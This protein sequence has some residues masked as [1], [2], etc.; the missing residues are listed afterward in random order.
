[1]VVMLLLAVATAGCDGD[2]DEGAAATTTTASER[3][4]ST[5]AATTTTVPFDVEV[6]RAAIEL[7]EIRNDVFMHPDVSRVAE[8]ISDTC[9]CLERERGIVESFV[10]AGLRWTAPAIEVRGIT[11]TDPLTDNPVLTLVARRANDA[12]QMAV[13]SSCSKRHRCRP[14]APETATCTRAA[15]PRTVGTFGDVPATG[16]GTDDAGLLDARPP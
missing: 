9:V 12:A 15:P 7:L 2:G 16:S 6:K 8:Y 1:M 5:S 3:T 11:L 13:G 10:A 14:A 4:T